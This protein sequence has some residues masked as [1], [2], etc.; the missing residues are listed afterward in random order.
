MS[1]ELGADPGFLAVSLHPAGDLVI[2]PVV[3]AVTFHQ[4]HGYFPSQR[5]HLPWPVPNYTA[6]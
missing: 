3:A 1:V 6:W 5:D 2:N 4:A